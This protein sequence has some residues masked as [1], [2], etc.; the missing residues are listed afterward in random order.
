MK[1]IYAFSL[2]VALLMCS[3]GGGNSNKNQ[4]LAEGASGDMEAYENGDLNAIEQARPEIMI[5][6]S[7]HTLKDFG[8]LR[9]KRMDGQQ[10][11]VRD[12]QK[13]MID[14]PKFMSVSSYVQEAFVKQNYPLT[15]FAQT[16]KNL[17]T[18]A[19]TDIAD[20]LAQDAKTRLL[21]TA[22]PDIVL[23]LNYGIRKDVTRSN[24][25]E[26]KAFYN[27]N[28]I[29]AYTNKVFSAIEGADLK[30]TDGV[31]LITDDMESRLPQL[32]NDVQ[33]Y[34]SDLLKRGREITVRINMDANSNQ[35]LTDESIEGDTYTDEIID[36]IKSHTVKGAYKMQTNTSDELTFA[37]VRIKML[38]EDGT[39]YGVYDWTRDLQKYLRKNLGLKTENR[40]Q[41][42]G[43]VVLTVKGM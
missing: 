22:H 33:A 4:S 14:D 19:A 30:G 28:A 37:N 8:C 23:E 24:V 16:L 17:D 20:N 3:C 12:Y 5:I 15:D 40:S 6:P 41:G 18:R 21:A 2:A 43:E 32:M 31:G 42:L 29:D 13:F 9:T 38:N 11:V 26:K 7:D 25:K 10:V 1:K 39:Q 34:F 35:K 27:I 36:Y